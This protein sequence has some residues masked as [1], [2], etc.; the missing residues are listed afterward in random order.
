MYILFCCLYKNRHL[1][2]LNLQAS[3]IALHDHEIA[4]FHLS[5]F[6]VKF[7]IVLRVYAYSLS[8]TYL[9]FAKL[10]VTVFFSNT[11]P[12]EVKLQHLLL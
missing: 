8:Y 9:D 2:G 11:Q 7:V 10:L 5:T 6:L 4:Y 12:V 1:F 3:N